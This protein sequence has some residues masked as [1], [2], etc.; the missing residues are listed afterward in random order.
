MGEKNIL[1]NFF[2]F[3]MYRDRLLDKVTAASS[4]DE[5]RCY[6]RVTAAE[7]AAERNSFP[8]WIAFFHSIFAALANTSQGSRD[9]VYCREIGGGP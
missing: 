4:G 5:R 9:R 7:T 8:P 1:I 6:I 3:P 2:R